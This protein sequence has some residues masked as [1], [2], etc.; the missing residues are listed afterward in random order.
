M[1][2]I[3]SIAFILF[4][5]TCFS[6]SST[7]KW[8]LERAPKGVKQIELKSPRGSVT[9]LFYNI[10]RF[11]VKET[12]KN[13]GK[14][15]VEKT[16]QYQRIDSLLISTTDEILNLYK[17]EE[18]YDKSVNKIF[19]TEKGE[20]KRFEMYRSEKELQPYVVCDNFV[21]EGYSLISYSWNKYSKN[22]EVSVIQVQ[23]KYNDKKQ[24]I[25]VRY[26]E[27]NSEDEIFVVNQYNEKGQL[28]DRIRIVPDYLG[29]FDAASL[30]GDDFR[31]DKKMSKK[32][33]V[34]TDFDKNGN[35]TT[36]FSL[37]K[38]GEKKKGYKRKIEYYK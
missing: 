15:R 5:I 28:T 38:D 9:R 21:Y 24:L 20:F 4:C 2:A 32:H 23:N 19:Y 12:Y 36:S 31:S 22:G 3:L 30:L 17:K 11:L 27:P 26:Y 1:K 10:D 13:R 37:L 7:P 16:Y 35:W 8:P 34:Y 18:N 14:I 29:T 33:I 6:Q 25:Q